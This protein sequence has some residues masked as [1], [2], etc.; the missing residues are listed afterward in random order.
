[1]VV[2]LEVILLAIFI[3][4]ALTMWGFFLFTSIR[5]DIRSEKER[6]AKLERDK[7]FQEKLGK[8]L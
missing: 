7:E 2:I 5:D 4:M 6:K 1:M 8:N 3:L